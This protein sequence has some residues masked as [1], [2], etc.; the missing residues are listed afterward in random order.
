MLQAVNTAKWDGWQPY[1]NGS[2]WNNFLD[3]QSYIDLK[4]KA[5]AATAASGSS[6][7]TLW[8]VLGAAVVVVIGAVVVLARRRRGRV[9]EE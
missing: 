6:P 3:R 1:M 5:V 9:V 2:V 8:I 7:A 4:P